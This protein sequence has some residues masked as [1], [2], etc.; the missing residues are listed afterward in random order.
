MAQDAD[1]R[2]SLE[3]R[4]AG[5][6]G[7]GIGE[8]GCIEID[9]GAVLANFAEARRMSGRGRKIIATVKADAYGHGC[10]AIARCLQDAGA[11]YFAAGNLGDAA[12]MRAAGVTAPMILLNGLRP[13]MLG[14][15]LELGLIATVSDFGMAE[16]MSQATSQ[17][18]S[19]CIKVD[20]GFGRFGVPLAEAQQFV[21]RVASLN[22]LRVEGVYTHIP[23]SDP[24][25]L[26]WAKARLSAFAALISALERD[27]LR[28]SI[29]QAIASAGLFAGLDDTSSAVAVGHVLYGLRPVS[30]AFGDCSGVAKLRPA[31]TAIRTRLVHVGRRPPE[32]EV[33]V[34][35]RNAA[36][37]VGVVPIGLCHGYRPTASQAF[38]I[39][40]G[41][42]AP[43]LRV[44]MENTVLDLSNVHAIAGD[45]VLLLGEAGDFR[46]SLDLLAEWQSTSPL[47]V[48][49]GLGRSLP[50]HYVSGPGGP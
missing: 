39:V 16:A 42:K 45:E 12:A 17:A 10:V 25:D 28:P 3:S 43:I 27:G 49:A 14:K 13:N 2:R 50:R 31:L 1:K 46:I 47:T 44:C 26:E 5:G 9:L 15:V 6:A 20:C 24:A 18:T 23:F 21:R 34:Y 7:E 38:M 48:V 22:R 32:G 40:A 19:I 4:P 8:S 35:L 41:H 37:A 11:D 29:T 33:H 36:G 30:P